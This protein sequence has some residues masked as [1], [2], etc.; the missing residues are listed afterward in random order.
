MATVTTYTKTKIDQILDTVIV[1]ADVDGSGNLILT[2]QNATTFNAGSVIGP[3][4][5]MGSNDPGD[6]VASIRTAKTG[7]LHMNGQSI[8]GADTAYPNLWAVVPASWKSGTTLI[9]PDM[10]NRVLQ[11]GAA[12]VIGDVTGSNTKI[13]VEA[14]LPPHTHTGPSHTHTGGAHT[15][16]MTHTHQMAHTHEHPHT[17][18]DTIAATATVTTSVR[19]SSTAGTTNSF[20][21]ASNTGV[22]D[23]VT[24]NPIVD[25]TITG[26]VGAASDATTGQPA[27]ITTDVP[28]NLSTGSG[29]NVTTT[30]SGTGATGVGNG[31]STAFDVQQQAIKVNY[32][33]KT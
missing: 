9:L 19:E 33:I 21:T 15:H 2:R 24:V 16:G 1:D 6:I 28:S 23:T 8:A 25:V 18:S 26:A 20:M 12:G 30:A 31:S 11:G 29:G 4:G 17:H 7:F 5:P 14:N 27:P 10:T 22:T 13:L 32:F 3:T